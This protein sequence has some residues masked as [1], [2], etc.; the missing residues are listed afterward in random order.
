MTI[1]WRNSEM[2]CRFADIRRFME[3]GALVYAQ[4]SG[5]REAATEVLDTLRAYMNAMPEKKLQTLGYHLSSGVWKPTAESRHQ[6]RVTLAL[7]FAVRNVLQLADVFAV[8]LGRGIARFPECSEAG[9]CMIMW[10][11]RDMENASTHYL[12]GAPNIS[13]C[14]LVGAEWPNMRYLQVLMSDPDDLIPPLTQLA[15]HGALH[16]H[17]SESSGSRTPASSAQGGPSDAG[18]LSTIPEGAESEETWATMA[19]NRAV[20]ALGRDSEDLEHG[21]VEGPTEEELEAIMTELAQESYVSVS[22]M[23]EAPV[24]LS[25]YFPPDVGAKC[26][27]WPCPWP[28]PTLHFEARGAETHGVYLNGEQDRDGNTYVEYAVS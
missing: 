8:R 4:N 25:G 17:G 13:T 15:Q 22:D 2:T 10:W 26:A 28:P 16:D 12:D 1:K 21:Q 20:D 5:R 3:F 6:P 27:H 11:Q 18:R 23:H 24:G 19:P 7:E 14:E 9:H